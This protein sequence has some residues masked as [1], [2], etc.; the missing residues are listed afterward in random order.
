LEPTGSA[1]DTELPAGVERIPFRPLPARLSPAGVLAA[2]ADLRRAIGEWRP[3]ILHAHYARRPAW[4][5]W[6]SGRRP[7]LV[8]VWGSD[9]L[10]TGQM[11]GV[12]RLATRLA[13]RDAAVV[14]A[15][16]GQL[17]TAAIALGA[18]SERLRAAELG[19][20]T[21]RFRPG[22]PHDALRAAF[23]VGSARV[24]LSP[25]VLA[26]IY[27]HEVVIDALAA[28]PGD[29]VVLSTGMLADPAERAR[30]EARAASIGVLDRWRILPAV[31]DERMAELYR[32]ATVVVSVPESDAM[33]QSVLEAMATGR[34]AVVSDLPDAREWLADLTPELIVPVGDVAAT[35]A[36]LRAALSQAESARLALGD[37]L[38]QRVIDR[39]D[40]GR[41]MDLVEA[42]YQ[43]LAARAQ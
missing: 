28:L 31:D 8:T 13:L 6:L 5:A 29:V 16:T 24:V 38:R 26:P 17:A 35:A 37:R 11:T 2:R 33:P 20:D 36:A 9:V 40:A 32:L 14:T 25:R 12:G 3:D 30:L 27:R 7:Y 19:V 1:S 15:A 39:A 22:P 42:W 18:R 23:G 41:G 4:H 21:G 34:P 10:V 43:E